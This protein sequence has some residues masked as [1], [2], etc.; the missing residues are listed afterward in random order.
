[1]RIIATRPLRDFYHQPARESARHV[2]ETW[3]AMARAARWQSTIDVKQVFPQTDFLSGGRA[4]FDLGGN[5]FRLVVKINYRAQI[6]FIRF[7]GTH[8]QYDRID[9]ATI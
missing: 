3:I 1:M 4:I 9:A 2:I 7:I 6:I 8:A 5:K